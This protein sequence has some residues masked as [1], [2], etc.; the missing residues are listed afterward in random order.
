[1]IRD[2]KKLGNGP[3][4]L[5]VIGGGIYGAWTAYD[6]ALRGLKVA[7]VEKNDW[8]SGTSS[9]SSKLIHGG[10]R[11][12][13]QFKFGLV[14][15]SLEERRLLTR[16]APHRVKTLRFLIPI[17]RESLVGMFRMG[18]GLGLYDLLAGR[19]QPVRAH[20]TLTSRKILS[21]YPFLKPEGLRG[22]YTYG[23]CQMDDARFTLE[24]VQGADAAGAAVVNYTEAG[25]LIMKGDR[26][27]GA[28]VTDRE[29]D[30]EI[31]V[32]A[33]VVVNTA[34]PWAP[35]F[36]GD[37]S[38]RDFVR[39][40]KG[41]HLVMPPLPTRDAMLIM[42]KQ[43]KRIMF[44]IPWY[45]KTLL[46]TTDTDFR[47]RPDN[48]SVD[49]EDIHYLLTEANRNF[50]G[51]EWDK[52]SILG[53]FAGLRAL[54]NQPGKLPSSVTREW[55]IVKPREGLLISVGGKF[56]S[57]RADAAKLVNRVMKALNK[58]AEGGAPTE[59][60]A[61]P[62]SPGEDF[63]EWREETIR[64]GLSL[65]LDPETAEWST[66]RYGTS[67][68]NI[69]EL[70]K[71]DA[72][73]AARLVPDL[74]FCRAEIVQGAGSEMAVGLEDLLRRR[75][76]VLILSQVDRKTLEDAASL[77]APMLG[78]TTERSEQEINGILGK[79]GPP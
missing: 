46:G 4:D 79:W 33:S 6:A 68:T 3:F 35:D 76:P 44:M 22:G 47:G 71:K 56:T 61:F 41:V 34:G 16:L 43:D 7:L 18:I 37:P 66:D 63:M 77:T 42:V 10:L 25:A 17:Y 78:W 11:Y 13:D 54:R 45:G 64:R 65:G 55:S 12:L 58:S 1:M 75:M 50:S 36:S 53:Q 48:V 21:A 60:R 59:S 52:S 20:E 72:G 2:P 19:N 38:R 51:T 69:H 39:L 27:M 32:L 57:A 23:D 24:I 40:T 14:R 49:E 62:W 29:E 70:I 5:L 26:V 74:P 30:K 8:A 28:M 73:L 9:A 15:T 67:I 31:E